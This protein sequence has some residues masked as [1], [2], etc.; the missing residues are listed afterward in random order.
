MELNFNGRTGKAAKCGFTLIELLVVIAIISLLAAIMFPVFGRVRE[1]ARRTSCL[2]NLKQ[3]GLGTI[4][5]SQDYDETMPFAVADNDAGTSYPGTA[6][7]VLLMPYVKSEQVYKCP[8]NVNAGLNGAVMDYSKNPAVTP[9][10]VP[11][12]YK[13]NGGSRYNSQWTPAR[14]RPMDYVRDS[15]P[16]STTYFGGAKLSRL[17]SSSKT[18]MLFEGR[19]MSYKRPAAETPDQY[20][21]DLTNHLANTNFLFCDGH[22]KALKPLMTISDGNM[23]SIDQNDAIPS[24]LRTGLT[25]YAE[26]NMQ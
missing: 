25:T 5:Y 1:S 13:A 2:S 24:Q 17:A 21:M 15:G 12:S 14:V 7:P 3:I 8:S 16:T 10:G 9:N 23:W 20:S 26:A 22:A 19:N 6:W 11:I 4:Q 18:I